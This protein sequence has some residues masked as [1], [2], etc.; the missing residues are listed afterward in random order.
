MKKITY[1]CSLVLVLTTFSC[2][3]KTVKGIADMTFSVKEH[4]FGNINQGDKVTTAFEFT[5]NSKNE[6]LIKEAHGSC[7]C[8]VPD[9]PKEPIAPGKKGVIKV[10]FNSEGKNGK[11]MKTVTLVAN[12]KSGS[13]VVTIY[14]FVNS[15][16]GIATY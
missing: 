7:G 2:Q 15:K 11:V 4:D 1:L 5:N 6:L 10:S 8:T 12:T 14:A 9:Y 16:R 13:E 3:K